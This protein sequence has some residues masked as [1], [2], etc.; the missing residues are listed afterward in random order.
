V[1]DVQPSRTI[2]DSD[3]PPLLPPRI[4]G[5]LKQ[6]VP[7][8]SEPESIAKPNLP[9]KSHRSLPKLPDLDAQQTTPAD[10]ALVTKSEKPVLPK[11]GVSSVVVEQNKELLRSK[12]GKFRLLFS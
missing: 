4:L 9:T 3:V 2:K 5:N 6:G 10:G 8:S 12:S 1:F 11:K 7:F